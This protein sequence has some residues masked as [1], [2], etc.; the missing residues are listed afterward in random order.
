MDVTDGASIAVGA[1]FCTGG[2][3]G[4]FATATGGFLPAFIISLASK[5]MSATFEDAGSSVNAAGFLG[6]VLIFVSSAPAA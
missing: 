6:S 1:V 5:S 2:R 4:G 3:A